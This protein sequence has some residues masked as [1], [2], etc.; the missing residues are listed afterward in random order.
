MQL[1]PLS[2]S[3]CNFHHV[4]AEKSTFPV[5]LQ[6]KNSTLHLDLCL[7]LLWQ[8]RLN[9]PSPLAASA[10]YLQKEMSLLPLVESLVQAAA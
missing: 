4:P 6:S 10:I 7:Y 2:I 5:H 3:I 1:H 8:K 9:P